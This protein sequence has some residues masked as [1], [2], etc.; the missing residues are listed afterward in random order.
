VRIAG[1]HARIYGH[2]VLALLALGLARPTLKANLI[3]LLLVVAGMVIRV[4]AAGLLE[5]GVRLCTDGPYRFVRHPL[6]LG[7]LLGAAGFALM[8]NV[9]WGWVIIFPLFAI[10]YGSQ[11]AE[12][13]RLLR[14]R[15]GEAHAQFA[16]TVPI[17]FPLPWRIGQPGGARWSFT[18]MLKNREHYHVVVTLV[19]AG[20]FF[21]KMFLS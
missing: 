14:Q 4:W 5:K 19:L 11:V 1:K 16:R 15:Y 10:L 3:G 2:F 7:S 13:E 21:G 12:E 8:M 6:Y 17:V 9:L 20:L 18:Q